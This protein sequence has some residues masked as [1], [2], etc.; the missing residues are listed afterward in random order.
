MRR[1]RRPADRHHPAGRRRPAGSAGCGA[2]GLG[3]GRGL[4]LTAVPGL[5]CRRADE[6]EWARAG[7][8]P[9]LWLA[10]APRASGRAG[11]ECHALRLPHPEPEGPVPGARRAARDARAEALAY[12][13]GAVAMSLGLGAPAPGCCAPAGRRSAGRSSCRTRARWPLLFLL[14]VAITANSG[15]TVRAAGGGGRPAGDA[16]ACGGALRHRRSRRH[17]RHAVYRAVHGGRIGGRAGAAAGQ[18]RWR[19]SAGWGWDWRSR[20]WHLASCPRS[21]RRLPTPGPWMVTAEAWLA[22]PMALTALALAW[23]LWR[24]GGPWGWTRSALAVALVVADRWRTSAW[25]VAAERR[26]VAGAHAAWAPGGGRCAALAA[27]VAIAAGERRC[28]RQ[29]AAWRPRWAPN[30]YSRRSLRGVAGGGPA[31]VRVFHRRLVPDLQGQRGDPRSTRPPSA[32][33][34]MRGEW[35]CWKATGPTAIRRSDGP[36]SGM[37]APACRSTCGRHRARPCGY[38]RRCWTQGGLVAL[39]R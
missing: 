38:C 6:P 8:P 4:A 31:G 26:Q 30:R 13:A 15:R 17:R 18:P 9:P 28:P 21:E 39:T 25:W 10:F 23:V 1:T 33:R 35:R 14:V 27:G 36:S 37:G 22:V 20:S 19:C 7:R 34:S 16:A 2:E 24:A 32:G 5:R 29:S 11:A 3:P 12:T